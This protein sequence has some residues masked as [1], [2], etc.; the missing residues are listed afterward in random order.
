MSELATRRAREKS[1]R[2]TFISQ[3][4]EDNALAAL[5]RMSRKVMAGDKTARSRDDATLGRHRAATRPATEHG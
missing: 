3:A 1:L 2:V 5:E 4:D